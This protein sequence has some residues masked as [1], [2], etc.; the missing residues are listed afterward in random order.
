MPAKKEKRIKFPGAVAFL[1]LKNLRFSAD[2]KIAVD[3]CKE[4]QKFGES[5]FVGG[6]VRD[7]LLGRKNFDFDIA[8]SLTTGEVK[9]I[10]KKIGMR[11]FDVG[12]RFG[13]IGVLVP[14]GSGKTRKA[15]KISQK[16][17]VTTFRKEAGYKDFR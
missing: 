14:G 13:T 12:E 11:F 1:K 15:G 17:E 3:F 9:R 4:L 2:Q 7:L 16:I 5:Y 10:T 6:A 8:T